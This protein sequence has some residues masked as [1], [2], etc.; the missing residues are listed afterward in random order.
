MQNKFLDRNEHAISPIATSPG[1]SMR[2]EEAKPVLRS[3][4]R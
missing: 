2:L 3:I 4:H 1:P